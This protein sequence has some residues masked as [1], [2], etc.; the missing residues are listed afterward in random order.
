MGDERKTQERR[1]HSRNFSYEFG[2]DWKPKGQKEVPFSSYSHTS[3]KRSNYPGDWL[4]VKSPY[5]AN[6]EEE[7]EEVNRIKAVM[8][9]QS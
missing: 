9:A 3:C 2:E 6:Y 8:S 5:Y 4:S 1:S 7:S